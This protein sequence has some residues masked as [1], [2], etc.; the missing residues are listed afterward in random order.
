MRRQKD[1]TEMKAIYEVY[2]ALKKKA[3]EFEF[4]FVP[5]KEGKEDEQEAGKD[6]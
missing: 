4:V 6:C 1:I 3:D 2:M 5:T